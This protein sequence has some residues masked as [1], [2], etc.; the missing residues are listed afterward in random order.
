MGRALMHI[1]PRR[2]A[3]LVAMLVVAVSGLGAQ[4]SHRAGETH[5]DPQARAAIRAALAQDGARPSPRRDP[6]VENARLT[7][8]DGA[9]GDWLGFSVAVDGDV[10]VVGAV[11]ADLQGAD[12]GAVYVFS[13]PDG[14]WANG[15]EFAKLTQSDGAA[16]DNFGYSVAIRGD[17]LVASAYGAD[18]GPNVDQGAVYVFH[19]PPGGWTD[20]TETAKLLA[21]DGKGQSGYSIAVDTNGDTVV[22]G[23]WRADVGATSRQGAVYVYSRPDAGWQDGTED[24]ILV[25]SDGASGD[26]FG[27]DVAISGTTLIAAARDARVGANARQGAVYVFEMPA[28][29]WVAGT[30]TAKLTASN[31]GVGHALGVSLAMH[32]DTVVAG[33]PGRNVGPTE[34]IG[35]VYVFEKSPSGWV[36]GNETAMLTASLVEARGALGIAVGVHGD[37]V[38]GSAPATFNPN[39][40]AV[41]VFSRPDGGWVDANETHVLGGVNSQGDDDF[42]RSV[43]IRGDRIVVGADDVDIGGNA[44]QG[45]AYVYAPPYAEPPPS[46]QPTLRSLSLATVTNAELP[47]SLT[48]DGADLGTVTSVTV[49]GM[50]VV[51]TSRSATSLRFDLPVGFPIGVHAVEATNSAGTSNSLSLT[52]AGSHPGVLV[53]PTLHGRGVVVDYSV[54]SDAGWSVLFMVSAAA[55]PTGVPGVFDLGIG[56][57]SMANVALFATVPADTAGE[58][59]LPLLMPA[60]AAVPLTLHWQCITFDPGVPLG[61]QAPLETTNTA[62]V[63][64]FF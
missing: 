53:A 52:L 58:V 18:V 39:V 41:F 32:G 28:N 38:I 8:S 54:L 10:V 60:S 19:R 35:A 51:L 46:P 44:N 30:E 40:G 25:A 56:G 6:F 3:E 26:D 13:P 49:G 22:V 14:G 21:S 64:T 43:A 15:T 16:G 55:G 63:Q 50:P 48:V 36:D 57:G 7:A 31:G 20:A 62:S 59:V 11:T 37:T 45:A 12:Q 61:V 27:R 34:S 17:T 4:S 5:V 33:A 2:W 47:A 1:L 23:A 9:R 24:A 29:G 42:G